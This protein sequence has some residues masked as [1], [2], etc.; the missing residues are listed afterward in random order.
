[1]GRI[2]D[3]GG[4]QKPERRPGMGINKESVCF[5]GSHVPPALLDT[6]PLGWLGNTSC[7]ESNAA[8]LPLVREWKHRLAVGLGPSTHSQSLQSLDVA[9][10][11]SEP[12]GREAPQEPEM[13]TIMTW[14]QKL[15]L[16]CSQSKQ[17]NTTRGGNKQ[18][19]PSRPIRRAFGDSAGTG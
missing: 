5:Q 8:I 14:L 12:H 15:Q 6:A 3:A 7:S 19:R 10:F 13:K 18:R 4:D 9:L 11:R 1:M 16:P 17:G 2:L